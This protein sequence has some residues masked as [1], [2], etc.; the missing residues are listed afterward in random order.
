MVRRQQ[1]ADRAVRP[2]LRSPGHP[3]FQRP[4]EVAFSIVTWIERTYHR[5]RRQPRLGRL[6]PDRI[7]G[8]Y[9]HASHTGCVTRNCHLHV[10]LAPSVMSQDIGNSSVS[11]HR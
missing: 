1:G 8:H 11:G 6:T 4:V 10:Q 5:R 3:K 9:E 7:R 2:R